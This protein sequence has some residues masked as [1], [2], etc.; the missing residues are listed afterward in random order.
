MLLCEFANS[1]I[2]HCL[3]GVAASEP[4]LPTAP[5][6]KLKE[7]DDAMPLCSTFLQLPQVES[8]AGMGECRA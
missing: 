1:L 5:C 7:M 2:V 3:K 8:G 6:L 4:H